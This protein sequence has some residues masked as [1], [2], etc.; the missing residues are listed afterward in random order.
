[1]AEKVEPYQIWFNKETIEVS[2]MID[3]DCGCASSNQE[4]RQLALLCLDDLSVQY[5]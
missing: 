2:N 3:I 1:M 4:L 5:F